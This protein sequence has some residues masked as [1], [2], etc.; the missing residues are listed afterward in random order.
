MLKFS[1]CLGII[2]MSYMT[3]RLLLI[4]FLLYDYAA[5]SCFIAYQYFR[6]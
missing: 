4:A 5:F 2:F 6:S 3:G 1:M